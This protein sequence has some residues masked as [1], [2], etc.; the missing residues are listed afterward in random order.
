MI[1]KVQKFIE[2]VVVELKKVSWT[3]RTELIDSTKVVIVSSAL[4]GIFI[5]VSDIIVSKLL[6]FI[7]K[8]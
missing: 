1:G 2:E 8:Y 4:L 6:S 5:V 3:T 7:I